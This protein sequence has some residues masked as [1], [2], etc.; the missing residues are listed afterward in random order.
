MFSSL[1]RPLGEDWFENVFGFTES[2]F[3]YDEIRKT[4]FVLEKV[5][6]P[7]GVSLDTGG[8]TTTPTT[9]LLTALGGNKETFYAGNMS[10]PSLAELRERNAEF[11]RTC[12]GSRKG[13]T[14]TVVP[15]DIQTF[16]G[17]R[18]GCVGGAPWD[19]WYYHEIRSGIVT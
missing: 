3:S 18:P 8:T 17:T 4:K 12:E 7:H 13:L 9:T 5:K 6:A 15:G 19:L 2:R 14:F 1:R 11:M 16:H 10:R